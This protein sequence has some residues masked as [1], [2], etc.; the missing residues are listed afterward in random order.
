MREKT[1]FNNSAAAFTIHEGGVGGMRAAAEPRSTVALAMVELR[2]V[3][4]FGE[5]NGAW[6]AS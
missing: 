1:C 2:I 4:Q 3:Q 5:I 6:T